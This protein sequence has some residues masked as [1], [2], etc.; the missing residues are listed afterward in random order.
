MKRIMVKKMLLVVTSLS[1]TPLAFTQA[2]VF[3]QGSSG[4]AYVGNV[5]HAIPR[6]DPRGHNQ[7]MELAKTFL[8]RCQGKVR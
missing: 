3:V 1:L 4:Y 8:Q 5:D 7:T 6:L 2:K